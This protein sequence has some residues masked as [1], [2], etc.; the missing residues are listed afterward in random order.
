MTDAG[1]KFVTPLTMR[2]LSGNPVLIDSFDEQSRWKVQHIGVAQEID[3]LVIAPATAN[4]VAKL[5]HGMA[6]NL[7]TTIALA[8]RAPILVV[9]SMNTFMYENQ[10]TQQNLERLRDLGMHVLEPDSG[11]LACGVTGKGRLPEIDAIYE[12]VNSFLYP[13]QDLE[14]VRVLITSGATCE[15]I[16]P[17]R[18]ITNRST[19]KMGHA[20]A[21][22]ASERGASVT[23]VSG[24]TSLAVPPGVDHC[25]VRS[26]REMYREVLAHYENCDVVIGAAAVADYR[27]TDCSD[28]EITLSEEFITLFKETSPVIEWISPA[29]IHLLS[30]QKLQIRFIKIHLDQKLQTKDLI[31]VSI[32]NLS[33][34]PLPKPI[35]NFLEKEFKKRV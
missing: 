16:D 5:A 35:N 26:A 1:T 31:A 23:L 22:A 34:Y 17:V 4:T 18:Y 12:K 13:R 6:D 9:P 24:P 11:N 20:L 3:L 27:P 29:M 25:P 33:S 32:E 7:L 15:D 2:T 14:G 10:A 30:H 19:G 21:Q 28:Q 8:T